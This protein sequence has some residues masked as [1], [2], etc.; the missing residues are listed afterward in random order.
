MDEIDISTQEIKFQETSMSSTIPSSPKESQEHF[1]LP[2]SSFTS[3]DET[4]Q[5]LSIEEFKTSPILD[6]ITC[7]D[8]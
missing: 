8:L 6:P 7:H 2:P 1:P 4:P 3:N 5:G